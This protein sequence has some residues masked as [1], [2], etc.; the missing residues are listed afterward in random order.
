MNEELKELVHDIKYH[1][2]LGHL[3]EAKIHDRDINAAKVILAEA[4]A[5][6]ERGETGRVA[7]KRESPVFMKRGYHVGNT[8]LN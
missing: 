7:V 1:V 8:K 2:M 4:V 5:Y 3:D 6:T